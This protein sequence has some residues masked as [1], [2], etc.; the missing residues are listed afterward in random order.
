M[1]TTQKEAFRPYEDMPTSELL[2]RMAMFGSM[3]NGSVNKVG[4]PMLDSLHGAFDAF[5]GITHTREKTPLERIL[6]KFLELT[7]LRLFFG[8]VGLEQTKERVSKFLEKDIGVML[9]YCAPEGVKDPTPETFTAVQA[10]YS[11]AVDACSELKQQY[12]NASTVSMAMKVSTFTSMTK[13]RKISE[14]IDAG[15]PLEGEDLAEYNKIKGAIRSVFE[16]AQASGVDVYIDAEQTYINGGINRIALDLLEEGFKVNMTVQAY[17]KSTPQMV[18]DILA[19]VADKPELKDRLGVKLV[20]GAYIKDKT[21]DRTKIHDKKEE[22]DRCYDAA[23]EKLYRSGKVAMITVATHNEE[24]LRL[25]ARITAEDAERHNETKV[26]S[27]TLMGMGDSIDFGG[28][29][30]SK[31]VPY[32]KNG[33]SI[34]GAIEYFGRRGVEFMGSP[35][36]GGMTRGDKE[37]FA[38]MDELK[39]RL[40]AN[41]FMAVREA[42]EFVDDIV[43]GV[44]GIPKALRGLWQD[45]AADHGALGRSL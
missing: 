44:L 10:E 29:K 21:E 33:D 15:Q 14:R 43:R 16:K 27:A 38:V 3:R 18:D 19:M 12:P 24:S 32:V 40:S 36:E 7:I 26:I 45:L 39:Q 23:F 25:A 28:L 5:Q 13:L 6:D 11:R 41:Q 1:T 42:A 2:H 9:D 34:M 20:R 17:L 8:G 31:Y 37:Y 35:G 4:L 30:R 22:S